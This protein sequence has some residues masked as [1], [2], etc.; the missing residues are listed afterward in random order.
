MRTSFLDEHLRALHRAISEGA[1]VEG[2]CHW[3]LLDNFEWAEGFWPRFG[4]YEVDYSNYS[5]TPRDSARFY[6]KVVRNNALIVD[7]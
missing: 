5:R 3:S 6:S 7:R 1:P 4:L 2:Y